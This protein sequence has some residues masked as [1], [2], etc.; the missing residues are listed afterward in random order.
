VTAPVLDDPLAW[1]VASALKA[2]FCAQLA[3]VSAPAGCCCLMPGQSVAWDSCDPGQAWVRVARVY[4]LGANFPQ[5]AGLGDMGPCGGMGGWAVVLELGA[6]R[7]LPGVDEHGNL[8]TCGQYDDVARLVYADAHAMRRAVMC[9]DW[10][11]GC[12]LDDAQMIV[13][14]WLPTGPQGNCTGG[15]LQVTVEV[16]GC[17]C[18]E[19]NGN[20]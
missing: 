14:D 4:Q 5:A 7:C 13:G 15:V 2:C 1:C 19:H 16:H 20:R 12:N 8:P 11:S 3:E 17:I 18:P 6:V 10:R 9:C